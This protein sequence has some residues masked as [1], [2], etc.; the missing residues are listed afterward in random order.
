MPR[1]TSHKN[2][3]SSGARVRQKPARKQKVKLSPLVIDQD[4]RAVQVLDLGSRRVPLVFQPNK[5]ARRIILRVDH[6]SA[7]VVVVLPARAS[8][9]EGR[10]FALANEAWI[11]DRLAKLPPRV[12]FR[13]GAV[14]PFMGIDH[15]IRHR[16]R[17]RGTVWRENGEINVTGQVEHLARRLEDWL[18][19]Q[20][21]REVERRST[22][23]AAE[24][25]KAVKSITIRDPKSRWASCAV[26]G[27]LSFSWRLVFAPRAVI[28]Y[29]VAHEVAHLRE[30][31]HGARFWRL[32]DSL[33]AD[34]D[35]ARLW[36]GEQGP[37]LH[38]FG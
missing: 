4:G 9:D 2:K 16:P 36:M 21:R 33:T 35:W 10:R 15:V 37:A 26:D 13:D 28:D 18:R 23:K 11:R 31:N 1:L 3:S 8:R 38:R 29:V 24:I 30:M 5:R 27:K 12:R 32:C 22:E 20:I 17:A 7:G 14:I 34:S 19:L 6:E 25:G